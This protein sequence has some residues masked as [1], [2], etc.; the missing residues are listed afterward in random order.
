M[1]R[2]LLQTMPQAQ[3]TLFGIHLSEGTLKES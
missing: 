1:S 3:Q 2:Q